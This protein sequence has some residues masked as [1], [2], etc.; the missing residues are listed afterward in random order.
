MRVHAH[1][2][3]ADCADAVRQH[4]VTWLSHVVLQAPEV[5]CVN[6]VMLKILDGKC[7][8]PADEKR[9]MAE[10]YRQLD[11]RCGPLLDSEAH[12]LIAAAGEHPPEAMRSRI[13]EQR[14]LAETR[15]ARP[16]MKA[17]KAMIRR[18]GLLDLPDAT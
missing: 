11:G 8:M 16:T 10:L 14:V 1:T 13:Y 5:D 7:K 6:A 18:T 17:F 15:I 9:V 3:T 2:A 12:R 4:V